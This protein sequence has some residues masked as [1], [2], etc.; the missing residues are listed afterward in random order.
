MNSCVQTSAAP[1]V[2]LVVRPRAESKVQA[3]LTTAR[4]ETFVPWHKVK[5]HWSDRTKIL[6]HN[7]FP[8]YVFCR[9]TFEERALV[10]NQPGVHSVVSFGRTP[11]L[12]PDEEVS[13]L[14]RALESGLPIGPWP[15][16]EAGQRVRIDEGALAG[17]EGTLVRDSTTWRIVMSVNALQRSIA[18]EVDRDMIRV[19]HAQ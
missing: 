9:S 8:G 4:L 16:L 14:R 10:M 6:E 18:V 2:A 19:I 5:R 13:A 11:A 12:I 15:H 7:L 17:T 1:W 3:G